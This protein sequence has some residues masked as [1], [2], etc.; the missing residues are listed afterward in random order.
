MNNPIRILTLALGLSLS[1]ASV[2]D[3]SVFEVEDMAVADLGID[4]GGDESIALDVNDYGDVVGWARMS[5]GIPH[6]FLYRNDGAKFDVTAS[7]G[8]L[9]G[10]AYGINN[11]REVVGHYMVP[12]PDPRLVN[13]ESRAFY[14]REGTPLQDLA[15][16]D[17]QS[18]AVAINEFGVIVGTLYGADPNG[19]T[20]WTW[21][22]AYWPNAAAYYQ[23][24]E[25]PN[26]SGSTLRATDINIHG[27]IS[28]WGQASKSAWIWNGV[29]NNLSK[30]PN[31][32]DVFAYGIN[33]SAAAVGRGNEACSSTEDGFHA[34]YWYNENA[35]P[36]DLGVFSGGTN[37][38]AF[39]INNERFVAGYSQKAVYVGRTP[40]IKDR[41][42]IWNAHFG[43]QEL[44]TLAG[45]S[46]ECRAM[47]L[48]ARNLSTRKIRVVGYCTVSGKKRAVRWDVTLRTKVTETPPVEEP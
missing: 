46:S 12:P 1:T 47:S 21:R 16:G 6:G 11:A 40:Y 14:W 4:F 30:G 48:N 38:E 20:C 13:P 35:E 25:C 39:E 41:A 7:I 8:L 42:F 34:T 28:G 10:Y 33:D 2:A 19:S 9:P 18:T 22:A 26:A 24:T 32:C 15:A 37:S 31:L 17:A 27:E 43:M 44:P 5:L 23:L 45:T 36:K 29:K 3:F